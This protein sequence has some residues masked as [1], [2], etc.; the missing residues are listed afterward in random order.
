MAA[1][2]E[3]DVIDVD[4]VFG[5]DAVHDID[6]LKVKASIVLAYGA[7]LIGVIALVCSAKYNIEGLQTWA[8]GLI[9][10]I[11]GAAIS[12]GFATK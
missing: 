3:K 8:T 10:A 4:N 5:D 2:G 11:V 9:S 1:E 7:M 6:V 12:Y